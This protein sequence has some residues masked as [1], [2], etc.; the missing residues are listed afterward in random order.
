MHLSHLETLSVI[1]IDTRQLS[2]MA[3]SVN[4]TAR[5]GARASAGLSPPRCSYAGQ[6]S[7]PATAYLSPRPSP[8]TTP[9]INLSEVDGGQ[10]E[11]EYL[12]DNGVKVALVKTLTRQ[13]DSRLAVSPTAGVQ[14]VLARRRS[15]WPADRPTRQLLS[16][17]TVASG[18][19]QIGLRA[20]MTAPGT[21][22]SGLITSSASIVNPASRS[23]PTTLLGGRW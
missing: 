23:Q 18:R 5:P 13:W 8:P 19:G 6:R 11:F 15:R 22:S 1:N 7:S 4:P 14:P 16:W 10:R 20:K 17:S 9:I 2:R 21:S 3:N 12:L